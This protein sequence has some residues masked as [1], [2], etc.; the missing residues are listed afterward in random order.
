MPLHLDSYLHTIHFLLYTQKMT[1]M[2]YLSNLYSV[3]H[4]L[5]L[6]AP[7]HM[8]EIEQREYMYIAKRIKK[9]K[10]KIKN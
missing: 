5:I 10:K 2:N 3:F 8:K 6:C 4:F 1:I 7:T 9:L